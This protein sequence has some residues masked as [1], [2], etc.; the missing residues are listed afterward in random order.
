MPD[1]NVDV[2]DTIFMLRLEHENMA[3]LLDVVEREIGDGDKDASIDYALLHDAFEYFSTYPDTCHHPIEELLY[4][5]LQSRYPSVSRQVGELIREH[6]ELGVLT[7]R[8]G[9]VSKQAA[10][11]VPMK[12][13]ELRALAREF[14]ALQR[15]HMA[16]EEK[17]LFIMALEKLTP[18]EWAEIDYAFFDRRDPLFHHESEQRF[19][20]LRGEILKASAIQSVHRALQGEARQL[21]RLQTVVEFNQAMSSSGD[22]VSLQRVPQGGFELRRGQALLTI[23]PECSETRAA[24]CAYY[25]LRGTS[26]ANDYSAP[27]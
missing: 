17:Q 13:E 20:R 24:W 6:E 25:F 2:A 9:E 7:K 11:A 22:N 19:A 3:S 16:T 21:S 14:V 15:R 12:D 8:L 1:N 27:V 5:K 10:R 23:I 4:R 26:Y 18:V